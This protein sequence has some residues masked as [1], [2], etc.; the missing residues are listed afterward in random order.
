MGNAKYEYEIG[1]PSGKGLKAGR[2]RR[3]WDDR[4][5]DD[6]D[7]RYD[8]DWDDRYDDDWDDRWDD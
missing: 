3:D 2:D 7:D 1:P 8:D 6:W 4:Y 5:D